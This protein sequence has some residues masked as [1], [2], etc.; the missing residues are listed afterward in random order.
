MTSPKTIPRMEMNPNKGK[1]QLF[2]NILFI[3]FVVVSIV[4]MLIMAFGVIT[5]QSNRIAKDIVVVDGSY[6]GFSVNEKDGDPGHVKV[7]SFRINRVPLAGECLSVWLEYRDVE[8]YID[9]ELMYDSDTI[10]HN[11]L[12]QSPGQYWALV[13]LFQNDM[14]R[15]VRIE[16]HDVYRRILDRPPAII[17]SSNGGLVSYCMRVEWPAIIIALFCMVSGLVYAVLAYVLRAGV[18]DRRRVNMTGFFIAFFGLYRLLDMPIIS[19]M[20]NNHSLLITYINLICFIWI[21]AV[22]YLSES[23][24]REF[25]ELFNI[26][27]K[28]FAGVAVVL[29]VLQLCGISDLR[30]NM[31]LMYL[32]MFLSFV[33]VMAEFLIRRCITHRYYNRDRFLIVYA[34][35]IIGI[36]CDTLVYYKNGSTRNANIALY[37]VTIYGLQSGISLTRR[38]VSRNE[39]LV[40]QKVELADRKGALMLSQMQPH[41]I[42]NTMNTIYSLCDINIEDAKTA[43]HDFSGYLRHNFGSMEQN[44]PVPFEDELKHTRFYLSIEKMRFGDELNVVYDIEES[45]FE[46]PPISLQ[47]IVENAVRHGLRHKTGGGTVTIRTRGTDEAYIV[48]VEDDGV[49]F[50][51]STLGFQEPDSE[52]NRIALN[53]VSM[54]IRQ[55]CD[56]TLSIESKP[57]AGTVVTISIPVKKDITE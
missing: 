46:L 8:I 19:L 31:N 24:R 45:D 23:T 30:Q 4:T 56:G 29:T 50:D 38:I 43:I 27:G 7:Y 16:T 5:P 40:R 52:H 28:L 37:L 12:S 51:T 2:F 49:G 13:P 1:R 32:G 39:E 22:F 21:P 48:T 17:L 35:I 33:A 47:P 26:I 6:P 57:G 25:N 41:F 9:D 11:R 42:Y 14:G 55:M 36:I 3:V 54:R 34:L 20:F 44:A 53:N 10:R 18:E 15:E